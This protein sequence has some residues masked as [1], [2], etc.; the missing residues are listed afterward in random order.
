MPRARID[1][2]SLSSGLQAPHQLDPCAQ[3]QPSQGRPTQEA[4]RQG[5]T[6]V[7]KRFPDCTVPPTQGSEAVQPHFDERRRME[8]QLRELAVYLD[9]T[10]DAIFVRDLPGRILL[11][12]QAAQ[13]LYGWTSVEAI[14]RNATEL[15]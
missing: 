3:E 7:D 10:S 12:N 13:R 6:E 2:D 11:W 4:F 1:E 5:Y 14:G 9:Q 15:L 8:E